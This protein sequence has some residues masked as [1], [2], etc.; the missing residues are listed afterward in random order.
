[1][2]DQFAAAA[3]R[4]CQDARRLLDAHR[5]DN[6]GY[7]A[8]Y[9]VECSLKALVQLGTLWPPT[10]GHHLRRLSG[11]AMRL[12]CLADPR[13]RRYCP[14]PSPE[15]TSLVQGWHPDIR[16]SASGTCPPGDA[17]QWVQAAEAVCR[18]VVTAAV[19]DGAMSL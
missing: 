13:L 19:L 11:P 5:W 14:A 17:E 15:L 7:L 8:G 2:A 9:V 4:H 16:Y 10:Y 18:D 3:A 12:A 1:M 6:A